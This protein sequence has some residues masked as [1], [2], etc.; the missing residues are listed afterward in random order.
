MDEK[1]FYA[2]LDSVQKGAVKAGDTASSV[3]YLAGKQA[4]AM[5]T[6]AKGN[7]RLARMRN[8]LS[9]TFQKLGELFYEDRS[10]KR[11]HAEAITEAFQKIESLKAEITALEVEMGKAEIVRT[12]PICGSEAREGDAYC[13]ECGTKL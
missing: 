5:R 11:D 6:S 9:K 8:E 1:K 7:L 2:V 12:C 3:A 13:R 10:G 4:D